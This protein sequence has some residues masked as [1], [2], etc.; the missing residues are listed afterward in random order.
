MELELVEQFKYLGLIINF[1]GSFKWAI[2]GI[3]KASRAMYVLIGKWRKLGLLIHLQIELF[4]RMI[5]PI[6]LYSCE[7]WWPE[8]YTETE[9]L[10]LKFLKHILVVH[11][12]TTNNMA[13]GELGRFSL[14]IQKRM[15]GYWERL[16]LGKESKQ[17]KLIYD[18]FLYLFNDDQYKS[19]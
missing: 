1:N 6:I 13:Y 10:H 5:V 11:G 15:I 9:K 14:E 3:K 2:T 4:D 12:R 7:V 16:I 17:C 19:K 8:N 18:Q